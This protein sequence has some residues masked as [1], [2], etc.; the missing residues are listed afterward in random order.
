[1]GKDKPT[2]RSLSFLSFMIRQNV[3]SLIDSL[4]PVHLRKSRNCHMPISSVNPSD[5]KCLHPLLQVPRACWPYSAEAGA[6][7]THWPGLHQQELQIQLECAQG[8]L[9]TLLSIRQL[10]LHTNLSTPIP[11]RQAFVLVDSILSPPT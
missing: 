9:L 3:S 6:S 2:S 4:N 5:D 10:L 7:I 8:F 1:M 11:P